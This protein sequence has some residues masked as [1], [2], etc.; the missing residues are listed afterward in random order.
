MAVVTEL[1]DAVAALTGREEA[2]VRLF[3]RTLREA[4][5]MTQGGRGRSAPH[6][7]SLDAARLLI[8]IMVGSPTR[9]VELCQEIGKLQLVTFTERDE[10]SPT[11][12][13]LC[14]LPEVHSFEDALSAL[15]SGAHPAGYLSRFV[16]RERTP[17]FTV[18]IQLPYL[19][20][21]IRTF[22]NVAEYWPPESDWMTELFLDLAG[23]T[24]ERGDLV[25]KTT[26]TSRTLNQLGAL[27]VRR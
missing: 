2:S 17:S 21:S 25:T 1:V 12:T 23:H 8:G 10:G 16:D 26:I 5:L 27:L 3:A 9:A 15:I 14:E 24:D 20:G 11:V 22:D 7:T 13:E 18:T 4:G 19:R 6:M